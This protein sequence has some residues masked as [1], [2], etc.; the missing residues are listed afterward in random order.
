MKRDLRTPRV[1]EGQTQFNV[2]PTV[3]FTA[4][5]GRGDPCYPVKRWRDFSAGRLV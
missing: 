1:E 3:G 4:S 2:K 5:L